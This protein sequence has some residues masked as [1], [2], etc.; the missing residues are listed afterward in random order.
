MSI[1]GNRAIRAFKM[2][3]LQR[4]KQ[5]SKMSSQH[6]CRKKRS[7]K[8]NH[9]TERRT[10]LTEFWGLYFCFYGFILFIFLTVVFFGI[11]L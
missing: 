6:R 9:A 1:I 11:N 5:V 3:R 10:T 8:C 7:L 2:H 4:R